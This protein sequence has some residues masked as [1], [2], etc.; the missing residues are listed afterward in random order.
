[1]YQLILIDDQEIT[2]QAFCELFN[3]NDFGFQ[4][5]A[6]FTNAEDALRFLQH[7]PID[8]IITDIK[9][10][11]FDGL[12]L[13]NYC[14]TNYPHIKLI[15]ISAYR[16]FEYAQEATKYNVINYITKPIDFVVFEQALMDAYQEIDSIHKQSD[17]H[18]QQPI[19]Q[20]FFSNIIRNEG[21]LTKQD[22]IN[23]MDRLRIDIELLEKECISF[24]LRLE[25][26]ESFLTNIWQYGM[27]RLSN[28]LSFLLP[29]EKD[30]F[31]SLAGYSTDV[32]HF[33]C[34]NINCIPNFT[35]STQKYIAQFQENIEN[36]LSLKTLNI[37]MQ[38]AP[39]FIELRKY[40]SN[41]SLTSNSVI[42]NAKAYITSHFDTEISLQDVADHVHMHPNYLSTIFKQHTGT[43][44]S[45]YL[46]TLRINKALELLRNTDLP[47]TTICEMIGYKNT[48]RFYNTIQ[49]QLHMT[50]TEYRNQWSE[51]RT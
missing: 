6:T 30:F 34:L 33:I 32:F 2:L 10:P 22:I 21:F 48:T 8:L 49:S 37:E 12:K 11:L 7:H 1:M 44:F 31:C 9:M 46:K 43:N 19:Y 16:N 39:N 29:N 51:D 17:P 26:L 4:L 18:K 28:A 27:A 50:P 38:F 5:V 23:E 14:H 45:Q 3:W 20:N 42:E 41:Y 24:S 25:N 40:L 36:N 35:E 15:L 13:A 47:V